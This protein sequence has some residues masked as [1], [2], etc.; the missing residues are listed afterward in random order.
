MSS[1]QPKHFLFVIVSA[2][3]HMRAPSGI[4]C[5]L[6]KIDP[7]L[8]FIVL[9]KVIAPVFTQELAPSQREIFLASGL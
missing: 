5:E 1:A 4:V 9:P 6:T 3:G 8:L 2:L 7:T